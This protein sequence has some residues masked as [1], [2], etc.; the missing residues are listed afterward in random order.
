MRYVLGMMLVLLPWIL[1]TV[2]IRYL[3]ARMLTHLLIAL[4][5]VFAMM[6]QFV[7]ALDSEAFVA[8]PDIH[9]HDHVITWSDFIS[10]YW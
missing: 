6:Y 4:S 1:L 10:G 3:L 8:H 5:I 9:G 2:L 7:F